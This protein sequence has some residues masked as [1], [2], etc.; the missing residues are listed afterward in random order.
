MEKYSDQ[1]IKELLQSSQT[2]ENEVAMRYLYERVNEQVG[3]FI[4][5]NR[6]GPEDVDDIFQ[7]GLI[8]MYKLA[9][10]GEIDK[11]VNMEAYLYSVCRNLWLK[12]LRRDKRE[13][14]L[15][16]EQE[17]IPVAEVSLQSLLSEERQEAL[18]SVL[19]ELGDTCRQ[20]LIWYYYDRLSMKEIAERMSYSG[21][22]VA[23]NKKS[24]C[25]K[26]LRQMILN[27]PHFRSL[28]K[29]SP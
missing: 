28:L 23:K 9:K 13:V 27:S 24:N 17:A 16:E 5:Q 29:N 25:L 2:G 19:G 22:Q 15:T 7:D 14:A 20:I 12:R 21:D 11:V 1:R 6:G 18:Q 8:A 10:K 3:R 26:K 4:L